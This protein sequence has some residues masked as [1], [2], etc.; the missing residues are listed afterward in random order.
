VNARLPAAVQG[1][2]GFGSTVVASEG[3]E[4]KTKLPSA[5]RKGCTGATVPETSC[6]RDCSSPKQTYKLSPALSLRQFLQQRLGIFQ[7][8]RV[9]TFGEQ[10]VD[11]HEEVC[12]AALLIQRALAGARQGAALDQ[13]NRTRS[14]SIFRGAIETICDIET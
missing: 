8:Q 14:R 11:R 6:E 9:E 10:V 5:V 4:S 7:V 12:R 13:L 2:V 3:P 1:A